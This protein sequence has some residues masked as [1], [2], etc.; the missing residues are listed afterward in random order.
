LT[1]GRSTGPCSTHGEILR[2]MQLLTLG[3]DPIV[4][5]SLLAIWPHTFF[6]VISHGQQSI[7]RPTHTMHY[8]MIFLCLKLYSYKISKFEHKIMVLF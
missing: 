7:E 1:F 3:E 5:W 4:N 2:T 6:K 8:L